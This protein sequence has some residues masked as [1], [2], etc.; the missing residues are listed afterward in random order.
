MSNNTNWDYLHDATLKHISVEWD[1]GICE[2]TLSLSSA[3]SRTAVVS[4]IGLRNLVLPRMAPWGASNSVNR[5]FLMLHDSGQSSTLQ[6]EMQSGDTI[7]IEAS[8]ITIMER[9]WDSP[10]SSEY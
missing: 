2:V 5:A 7:L 8:S 3:P 4:V 9:I 6:I 1:E 10:P